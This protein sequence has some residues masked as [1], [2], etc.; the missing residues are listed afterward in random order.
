MVMTYMTE[1]GKFSLVYK[2]LFYVFETYPG[3]YPITW[4][5]SVGASSPRVAGAPSPC[6]STSLD[7][8]PWGGGHGSRVGDP[9]ILAETSIEAAAVGSRG[10][11]AAVVTR[12]T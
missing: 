2:Y 8:K 11:A 4:R 5:A 7:G 12:A 3:S 1:I 9:G 10:S 6:G